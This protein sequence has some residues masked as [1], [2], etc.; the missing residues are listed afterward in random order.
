MSNS[1]FGHLTVRYITYLWIL[2]ICN[3]DYVEESTDG[4]VES[5]YVPHKWRS[6]DTEGEGHF[7]K[8]LPLS[9]F[10]HTV[11]DVEP[12]P[13]K[14]EATKLWSCTAMVALQ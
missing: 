12:D 1:K 6:V 5:F 8:M 4:A 7:S 10:V 3:E 2:Q 14:F 11:F 13:Q 9:E